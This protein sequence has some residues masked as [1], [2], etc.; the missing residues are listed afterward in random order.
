MKTAL[1]IYQ[2]KKGTTRRFGNEIGR[3]LSDQGIQTKTLSI[4]ECTETIL[5]SADYLFL[6]CWTKGWMVVNQHPDAPWK[7]W[8]RR[9]KI[10][11]GT[12]VALFTTYK[13]A[14]GSMFRRMRH[15]LNGHGSKTDLE[16]KS[17]DGSLPKDQALSI[18]RFIS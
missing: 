8:A 4:E 13:L 6:G 2:S 7:R 18:R 10:A 12:R 16:L 5:A 15:Q 9:V 17:R 1:I 11:E 14:T 3:F